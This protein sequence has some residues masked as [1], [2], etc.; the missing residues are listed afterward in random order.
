MIGLVSCSVTKLLRAAPARELYTSALFRKSLAH[1]ERSCERVYVLSALH[2]LVELD[3]RLEPYNRRL[4]SKKERGA[5]AHRVAS[6]LIDRHGRDVDYL[7]LAGVDYA[8][9]LAT[10]L[11]TYDG[12]REDGWRG[13][14]RERIHQPLAKLKVGERLRWLNDQIARSAA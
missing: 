7:L 13:V 9:P 6:H 11:S 2:G 14:P 3:C 12:F 5:W 8:G 10:A 4:G 1:A